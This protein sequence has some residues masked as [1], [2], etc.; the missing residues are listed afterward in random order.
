MYVVEEMSRVLARIALM[1]L[2]LNLLPAVFSVNHDSDVRRPECTGFPNGCTC[3]TQNVSVGS[4]AT[5]EVRYDT[6]VVTVKCNGVELTKV[7]DFSNHT[8]LETM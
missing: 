2:A 1:L 3:T 5:E 8:S 4:T 7:P 6:I